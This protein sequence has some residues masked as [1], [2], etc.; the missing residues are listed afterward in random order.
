[1][2]V[3]ACVRV[4]GDYFNRL[5]LPDVP[6]FLEMNRELPPTPHPTSTCNTVKFLYNQFGK[7]VEFDFVYAELNKFQN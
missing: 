1:M 5:P 6:H 4:F 7:I 2:Y 3:R